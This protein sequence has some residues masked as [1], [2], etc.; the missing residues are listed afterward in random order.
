MTFIFNRRVL[1]HQTVSSGHVM[2]VLVLGASV[3]AEENGCRVLDLVYI[4]VIMFYI[5]VNVTK[6]RL[7][8]FITF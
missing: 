7:P 5:L 1:D 3:R 8:D 4:R 6:N 2:G